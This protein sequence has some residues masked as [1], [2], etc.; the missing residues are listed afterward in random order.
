[1]NIVLVA[2]LIP[3][4]TGAIGRLCVCTDARL[5]LIEPLGF[6]I[7]DKHIKKA[8]MD[9]WKHLDVTIH[10]DWQSFLDS[11]QPQSMSFLSTRG[12]KSL[13]D[14]EFTKHDYLVFGNESDGLP[15]DFYKIY[16]DDLF[17]IPMP[18]QNSR[19]H[20]LA[21]SVSIALYEAMR[22]TDFSIS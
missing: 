5:H 10:P 9:Y 6:I 14:I 11:E 22:Q 15:R 17:L 19:S 18:G 8:G 3:Q 4:N 20:N 12:K 1:M 7:D 21:N 2:P 16:E 13:Y